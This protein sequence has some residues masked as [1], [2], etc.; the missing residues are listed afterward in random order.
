VEELKEL[1]REIVESSIAEPEEKG[2]GPWVEHFQVAF[3]GVRS[4]LRK[5]IRIVHTGFYRFLL[6]PLFLTFA[7]TVFLLVPEEAIRQGVRLFLQKRLRSLSKRIFDIL[8]AC[9]GLILSIPIFVL[10]PVLI[11]L[12]SRGP[13][14]YR[15]RRVGLNRRN[16]NGPFIL[17]QVPGDCRNGD[18][19]KIDVYGKPFTLLKFRTMRP[20]AENSTGPVWAQK[21]DPRVTRLGSFLRKIHIDELPQLINVLKGEMSLI[22]PRPE[23]PFIVCT[24]AKQIDRYT[25]RFAVKPGISGLAQIS[26]GYDSCVEDVKRKLKYDLEY[27]ERSCLGLDLKISFLTLKK[28]IGSHNFGER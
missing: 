6:S 21:D 11:K 14:F 28:L 27:I 18:R 4:I 26:Q 2:I 25:E 10:V 7:L 17:F 24:L 13:V 23:R 5:G 22:G 16:G 3:S 12:D 9:V 1:Q 20:D 19:R 15:Q 8:G